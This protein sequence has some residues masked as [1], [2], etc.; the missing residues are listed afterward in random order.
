MQIC[1]DGAAS[2]IFLYFSMTKLNKPSQLVL[3]STMY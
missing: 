3:A 1:F 2:N